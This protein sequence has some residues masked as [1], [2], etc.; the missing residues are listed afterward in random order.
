MVLLTFKRL[1]F[2]HYSKK[3]N[4]FYN[5][6]SRVKIKGRSLFMNS[7]ED[8]RLVPNLATKDCDGTVVNPEGF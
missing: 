1:K 4:K 7:L 6:G 5:G 2:P 8:I 3:V